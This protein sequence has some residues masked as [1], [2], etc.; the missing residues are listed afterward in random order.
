MCGEEL[1]KTK[2]F[3]TVNSQSEEAKDYDFSSPG[4]DGYLIGN[5]K[6]IWTAFSCGKCSKTYSINDI[7]QS[8]KYAKKAIRK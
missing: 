4:G 5:V 2:I 1:Q 8:E 6:F 7:Y 3:K